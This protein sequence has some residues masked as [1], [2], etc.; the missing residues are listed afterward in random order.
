MKSGNLASGPT[1]R[2]SGYAAD[3]TVIPMKGAALTMT[4]P[5]KVRTQIL[6]STGDANIRFTDLCRV[7]I[8]AGYH[9]RIVGSHH[10]FT[11]GGTVLFNLQ[12][13]GAKAKPYQVRQVRTVLRREAT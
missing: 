8:R 3:T 4:G 11:R 2:F 1:C 5:D 7:L 9:E 12:A 6:S 10:I 13:D